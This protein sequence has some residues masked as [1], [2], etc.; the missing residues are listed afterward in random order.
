MLKKKNFTTD[1][2]R[3]MVKAVILISEIEYDVDKTHCGYEYAINE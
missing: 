3:N 1:N 2:G